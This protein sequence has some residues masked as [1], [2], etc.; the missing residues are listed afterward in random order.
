[1]EGATRWSHFGPHRGSGGGVVAGDG[2]E[3]A[4]APA[5]KLQERGKR[6]RVGAVRTDGGVSLL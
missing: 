2:D 3:A 1:M 6:E 4:A 5:L